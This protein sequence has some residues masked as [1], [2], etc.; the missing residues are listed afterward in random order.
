M[1]TAAPAP[2]LLVKAPRYAATPVWDALHAELGAALAEALRA[3][4]QAQAATE[5]AMGSTP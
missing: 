1:T 5:A 4:E 3:A 2:V